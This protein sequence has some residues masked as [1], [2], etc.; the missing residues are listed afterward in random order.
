MDNE[1]RGQVRRR[2]ERRKGGYKGGGGGQEW[3]TN[4]YENKEEDIDDHL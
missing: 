3:V 2:I 4:E 1:T